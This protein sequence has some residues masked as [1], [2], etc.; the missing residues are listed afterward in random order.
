MG[1]SASIRSQQDQGLAPMGRSYGG[2]HDSRCGAQTDA[3][4]TKTKVED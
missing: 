4:G 2:L 1:A 3:P